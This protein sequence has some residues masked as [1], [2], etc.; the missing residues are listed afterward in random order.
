MANSGGSQQGEPANCSSLHLTSMTVLWM[1]G[2]GPG[3]AQKVGSI[4]RQHLTVEPGGLSRQQACWYDAQVLL[5]A[6]HA[7][8]QASSACQGSAGTHD[9]QHPSIS[10]ATP[11][12]NDVQ[13]VQPCSSGQ[14]GQDRFLP[15]T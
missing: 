2:Q 4:A 3:A 1:D 7:R 9:V 6:S 14:Q 12:L 15:F 13:Q 8:A 11:A 10:V 5:W